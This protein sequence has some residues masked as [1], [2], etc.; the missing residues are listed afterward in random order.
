MFSDGLIIEKWISTRGNRM[1]LICHA[2]S[3]QIKYLVWSTVFLK[4]AKNKEGDGSHS[5]ETNNCLLSVFLA[6]LQPLTS[7][8]AGWLWVDYL[9]PPDLYLLTHI[10]MLMNVF[11]FFAE[12]WWINHNS[13]RKHRMTIQLPSTKILELYIIKNP[14]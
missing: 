4:S 3:R 5:R 13:Q 14:E 7:I 11:W 9:V 2:A 10:I 12:I 8:A 6:D 1:S